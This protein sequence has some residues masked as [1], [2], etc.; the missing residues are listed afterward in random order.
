MTTLRKEI[1]NKREKTVAHKRSLGRYARF[2]GQRS[3]STLTRSHAGQ[4]AWY[5]RALSD[6]S[7]LSHVLIHS[8]TSES[9]FV[10]NPE[11]K[12]IHR[13]IPQNQLLWVC[14]MFQDSK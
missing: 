12:W 11:P 6:R 14:G 9:G 8:K 10:M 2:A 7:T 1:V 5:I 3:S 13:T 4:L